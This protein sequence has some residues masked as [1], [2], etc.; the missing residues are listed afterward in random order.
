MDNRPLIGITRLSLSLLALGGITA[1][2]AGAAEITAA[3]ALRSSY[4]AVDPDAG[5]TRGAFALNNLRMYFKGK[6]TD[7]IGVVLDLDYTPGTVGN[8]ISVLDAIATFTYSDKVNLWAGR[9]VAPADRAS[10]GGSYR[11]SNWGYGLDGVQAGYPAVYA[12]RVDGV[13]YWGNFGHTKVSAGV[14]NNNLAEDPAAPAGGELK[15]AARVQYDFLDAEPAYYVGMGSYGRSNVLALGL[16]G[17]SSSGDSII[18]LDLLLDYK[19]ANGGVVTAEGEYGK[20]D[21]LGQGRFV[22]RD[23]DGWFAQLA[24]LFARPVGPGRVQLLGHEGSVRNDR[25]GVSTRTTELN[26]NYILRAQDARLQLFYIDQQR[27]G[28]RYGLG[29]QLQM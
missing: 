26:L 6:V 12:C 11:A 27:I 5:E 21:G 9:Q 3:G 19:L 7:P 23:G 10:L 15:T 22:T 24:Y 25:S 29:L 4:T 8:S 18:T 16:A 1:R 28:S 20:Y 14:Y 13:T 2:T 17:Q